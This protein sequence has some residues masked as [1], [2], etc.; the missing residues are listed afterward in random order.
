MKLTSFTDYSLRVLIYLG[1]RPQRLATIAQIATAYEVSEHH[2]TKVVHFLG[3]TGLLDN[4]RAKRGGLR[5]AKPIQEITV[6]EVVRQ[7]ESEAAI[8][9]CFQ[10][11]GG[12]CCISPVCTLRGVL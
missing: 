7:T 3:K 12:D 4:I 9:E 8:T 1:L 10:P 11:A 5:L 6:G 2:L